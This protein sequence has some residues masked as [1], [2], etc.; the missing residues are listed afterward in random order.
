MKNQSYTG[1]LIQG[2]RKRVSHRFHTSIDV[3]E[4]EWIVYEEHHEALIDKKTFNYVQ[5]IVYKNDTRVKLNNEY[6][7]FA[8]YLICHDCGNSFVKK[9]NSKKGNYYCSSYYRKGECTKHKINKEELEEVVLKLINSQIKLLMDI[10]EKII[11][12]LKN[13]N[14]INYDY[15]IVK[16]N[17]RNITSKLINYNKLIN[18]INED[19]ESDFISKEELLEY[20]AEYNLEINKLKREKKKNE[21]ELENINLDSNKN[22]WIEK[23]KKHK[24]LSKLTKTIIDELIEK[25]EIFE[26]SHIKV[27]FKYQSEYFMALD[28]INN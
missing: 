2:K 7:I 22:E 1:D 11:E 27:K 9:M 19:Y 12:T 20:K 23:F 5:E 3:K 18:D 17:I 8:G 24:D 25:V 4:E 6:D 14:D 13:D 21:K 15:E 26:N 10:D 16:S 28:F